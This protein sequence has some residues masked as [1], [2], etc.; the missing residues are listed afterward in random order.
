MGIESRLTLRNLKS[1]PAQIIDQL[2]RA[3]ADEL[4]RSALRLQN[5]LHLGETVRY[6]EG[7]RHWSA[8]RAVLDLGCG[9]GD[10]VSHLS[11]RFA[12]K[13][14]AG[15]DA[16]EGFIALAR[17]RTRQAANCVFFHADL[18]DF[19]AGRYDFVILRAVLQ[20]LGDPR[21]LMKHLTSLLNAGAAVLFLETTK[22]NF[23]VADPP[24]PTFDA[25][26]GRL[27]AAQIEAGGSRDCIVELEERLGESAFRLLELESPL[28][29]AAGAAERLWTVQYL[30]LS[31]AI[32]QRRLSLP[33]SFSSLFAELIQWHE[34]ADSRMSFK[35]RRMLIEASGI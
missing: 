32:S 25:F 15:V 1:F 7:S 2:A 34:K 14:Y 17:E 21:R 22:E 5:D 8:A 24:I 10:L 3:D 12:E 28:I 16:N 30:I 6:L 23:V 31:C 27:E 33:I 26:Y 35:S 18:Y 9:P 11:G 13:T 20:H 4:Y 29:H 19:A